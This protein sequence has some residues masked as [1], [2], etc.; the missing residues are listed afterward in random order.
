MT[1]E[2]TI[3]LITRYYEAFNRGDSERML[4]CL[5]EDVVHDVNQGSRREGKTAFRQFNAISLT[6][7]SLNF[8]ISSSGRPSSSASI[9]A[10][11]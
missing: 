8:L 10:L 6:A 9:A 4:A 11:R 1:A 7:A 5:A 2:A 3:A